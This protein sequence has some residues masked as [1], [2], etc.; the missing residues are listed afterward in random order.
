MEPPNVAM[1]CFEGVL[2]CTR[3]VQDGGYVIC[4]NV[5]Q[6]HRPPER[7]EDSAGNEN[8]HDEARKG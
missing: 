5:L 6:R 4:C 7:M 3:K 1:S 8:K 2:W